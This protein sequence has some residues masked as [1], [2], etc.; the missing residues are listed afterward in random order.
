MKEGYLKINV[1]SVKDDRAAIYFKYS[2][3]AVSILKSAVPGSCRHFC[4]ENR[5]WTVDIRSIPALVKS[6]TECII[7]GMYYDCSSL[8]TVYL[9]YCEKNG[10][11]NDFTRLKDWI[12]FPQ[13]L[14]GKPQPSEQSCVLKDILPPDYDEDKDGSIP[15]LPEGS[16]FKPYPHQTA[17]ARILLKNHKFILADT[18]GLGKTFTAIMAAYNTEGRKLIV[19]PASLKLN[20][21]NEI[22]KFGIPESDICVISSRTVHDDIRSSADWVIVN[23]DGL[24]CV[25][26][27]VVVPFWAAGFTTVIFDEAHY[28]KAVNAKGSPG[29]I[30]SRFSLEIARCV[31]NVYLLTGT[32]ITN[33]TKDIFMLLKMV[34]SPLA[35]NWFSFAHR[36]C[37]AERNDF[38]WQFDGSTNQE[39][40]NGKLGFCLLRRRIENILDMPEKLRTY[41]PVEADL[42]EY[43]SLLKRYLSSGD[44]EGSSGA[45]AALGAMKQAAAKG[46][47]E[48][49]CA[50]ISDLLE[51][52][53]SVVAY[54]CYLETAERIYEKFCGNSVKITGEVSPEE[55]QKAVEQFQNGDKKVIVC[56]VSAGGVGLTL[57]RS[58][59]VVFNDFD[60]SAASMRQAEDRIWRIGQRN[61]CSIFYVYADKCMLDE[62]LCSML[63]T[64]LSNMGKIIDG[65]EE[66][67]V[68]EED[69]SYQTVLLRRLLDMKQAAGRKRKKGIPKTAGTGVFQAPLLPQCA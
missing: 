16:S 33:K 28:C 66:T 42:K 13:E 41:I 20:W 22:M 15:A 2:E 11:E 24:R 54:T 60:Y 37:G 25:H 23:Y 1:A 62:T 56:T 40:L 68:T 55:R 53:K 45:L 34:D 31:P 17:G 4:R 12:P 49:T 65:K 27:E 57:T 67:L 43:D 26:R 36:Y 32:P 51:N 48:K 44:Y 64:K 9:K 38:G 10:I 39:E 52:G 30:R 58:D 18:M 35:R 3:E 59:V 6:F 8:I 46:K 14:T 7:G 61:A 21:R 63:N 19:T 50:L 47:V 5:T 69:K 29:S